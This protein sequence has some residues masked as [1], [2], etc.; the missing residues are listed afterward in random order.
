MLTIS[1]KEIQKL[2]ERNFPEDEYPK[3]IGENLWQITPDLIGNEKALNEWYEAG[4]G[5]L[6]T[7]FVPIEI[8]SNLTKEMIIDIMEE[9]GFRKDLVK[10]I[11]DMLSYEGDI[12]EHPLQGGDEGRNDLHRDK[13]Q[14]GRE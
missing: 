6:D 13:N 5:L 7:P 2:L 4:K 3:K 11:K 1:L 14:Q 9:S 12:Q 10:E 8:P